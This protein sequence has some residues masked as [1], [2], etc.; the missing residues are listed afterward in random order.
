MM[1]VL[2]SGAF[3]GQIGFDELGRERRARPAWVTILESRLLYL[4]I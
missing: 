4:A 3:H 2:T 1:I